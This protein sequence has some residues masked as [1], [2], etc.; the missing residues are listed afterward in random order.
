M[1][2]IIINGLW[3]SDNAD[4]TANHGCMA[5]ELAHEVSMN[6]CRRCRKTSLYSSPEFAEKL[7]YYG[8]E[9]PEAYSGRS[10]KRLGA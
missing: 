4:V 1:H 5:G 8:S 7:W 6:R 10:G 9:I 3:L 2:K